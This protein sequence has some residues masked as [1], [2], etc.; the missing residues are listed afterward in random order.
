[1]SSA[2]VKGVDRHARCTPTRGD[3]PRRDVTLLADRVLWHTASRGGLLESGNTIITWITMAVFAGPASGVDV[4]VM[5]GG[6]GR[7]MAARTCASQGW[8]RVDN[9]FVKWTGAKLTS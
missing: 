7:R 6:H 9:T 8:H 5:H 2:L 1:M 4:S 3:V